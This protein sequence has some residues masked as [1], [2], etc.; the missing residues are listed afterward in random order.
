MRQPDRHD[1]IYTDKRMQQLYK[2]PVNVNRRLYPIPPAI[3]AANRAAQDAIR[4]ANADAVWVNYRLINVQARPLD[5]NAIPAGEEPTFYLSN[6]VV[7]TN[8]TLQHFSGK[9][10]KPCLSG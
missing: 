9:A 10:N 3:T 1:A 6:E 4:K 2:L 5:V 8:P 7:E